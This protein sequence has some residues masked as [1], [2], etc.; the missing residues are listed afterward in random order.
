MNPPPLPIPS[1]AGPAGTSPPS[2]PDEPRRLSI[3]DFITD[4]SL[5]ALCDELT[6]LTGLE[7]T[8]R[9]ATGRRIVRIDDP[10]FWAFQPGPPSPAPCPDGPITQGAEVLLPLCIDGQTIGSLALGPGTPHLPV[11]GARDSLQHALTLL[12]ST[13][14]ELCRQQLDLRHRVKEVQA[15]YRLSSLL[16]RASNLDRILEIALDSAL[17][18]L[19]LEA[20]SIV[21]FEQDEGPTTQTEVDLVLKTSR[22]LSR[23]WLASPLP[24]SKD[25]LFDRMALQGE[26]VTSRDLS[27]DPRVFIPDMVAHEGLRAAAHAG[28]VFQN[29][30]I[31]VMRLYSRHPRDF[32]EADRSILRSIAHQAAVAVEQARLLKLQERDAR[33]QRQVQL[34]A[35]VQRRMLPRKLPQLLRLDVASRY[36]PSFEL[37]GDFYDF[38]ELDRNLGIA[39]G[40]VV[41]KGIAAALLMSA[42]RSSL[43]AHVQDVYHIDDVMSRVN[44]A[45][46]RDTL[47]NEFATLWYGVIEA[48][49][50]RLTYCSG[51]HEPPLIFRATPGRAPTLSDIDELSVGG[52]A[53]G[54]DPTQRYQRG[55]YDLRPGDVFLAYTDGVTDMLDFDGKKFGKPR[56]RQTVLSLLARD[57]SAAAAKIVD[58]VFWELRQ[59]GGILERPDDQTVVVVRIK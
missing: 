1:P 38:M 41:G 58:Q 36:L 37:G 51:G 52:M 35:D 56:L 24:L 5:A 3:T 17:D 13:A 32:S 22:N 59:F 49:R 40:D 11:A 48:E 16:A 10:P 21:L 33:I 19:G 8:L 14:A 6:R 55:T 39:I 12:A 44:A 47:D 20:G 2:A 29:K 15:L 9:D 30:A 23:E 42:V 27:A 4:G 54:I 31:G 43:R 25:R 26:I 34:A 45:L 7:L 46:C 18:V 28:M 50:L 57:P 53:V